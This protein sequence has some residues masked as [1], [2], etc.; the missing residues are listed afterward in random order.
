LLNVS[1][2][3]FIFHDWITDLGEI[4]AA[5]NKVKQMLCFIVDCGWHETCSYQVQHLNLGEY[6]KQNPIQKLYTPSR[7]GIS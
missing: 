7:R 5:R 6:E 4:K 3:T 2:D 1:F